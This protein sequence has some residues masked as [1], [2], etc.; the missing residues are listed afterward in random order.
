MT[1]NAASQIV[2]IS[3]GRQEK[4]NWRS[5]AAAGIMSAVMPDI[6]EGIYGDSGF[7]SSVSALFN[8]IES[9]RYN[10][11]A[12]DSDALLVAGLKPANEDEK[13]SVRFSLLELIS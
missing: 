8:S 1:A 11:F 2:N 13:E 4:F 9:G 7:S 5:V 6:N 3:T 12:Q 10:C